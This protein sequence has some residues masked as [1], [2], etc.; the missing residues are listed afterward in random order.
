MAATF[1][2]HLDHDGVS[3]LRL[4]EGDAEIDTSQPPLAT[5]GLDDD[6]FDAR[7]GRMQARVAEADGGEAAVVLI[8]PDS[9]I[10]YTRTR[11]SGLDREADEGR[12]R[13]ALVGATP[14]DLAELVYDWHEVDGVLEIAVVA[15][16]TLDEARAFAEAHGVAPAGVLGE[17]AQ[18]AF[19]G[20]PRFGG[21]PH[22]DTPAPAPDT[23]APAAAPDP[24][25]EVNIAAPGATEPETAKPDIATPATE[26]PQPG[27][28]AGAASAPDRPGDGRAPPPAETSKETPA[29]ASPL[30]G[31]TDIDA[32]PRAEP[33]P[34]AAPSPAAIRGPASTPLPTFS[35]IRRDAP[36]SG[37]ESG[38][39]P[40]PKT[41]TDAAPAPGAASQTAIPASASESPASGKGNE[42][43]VPKVKPVETGDAAAASAA[44]LASG[45]GARRAGFGALAG[46]VLGTLGGKRRGHDA[47]AASSSLSRPSVEP[48]LS[49]QSEPPVSAADRA[50]PRHPRPSAKPDTIAPRLGSASAE[51]PGARRSGSSP[52]APE[53][54]P[55]RPDPVRRIQQRGDA[56]LPAPTGPAPSTAGEMDEASSLTVFG[57]RRMRAEPPARGGR[58]LG[59]VLTL[60]LLALMGLVALWSL[61]VDGG[62]G[63]D[64]VAESPSDT[65]AITSSV[66]PLDAEPPTPDAGATGEE[67]RQ[68]V[69]PPPADIEPAPALPEDAP[70]DPVMTP[71]TANPAADGPGESGPAPAE[72]RDLAA[73]SPDEG[74]TAPAT[75]PAR[76]PPEASVSD[77]SVA[78]RDVSPDP[79]DRAEAEAAY[80]ATGIW[81]RA[82][83]R[84]PV[85]RVT[86]DPALT[87]AA[88]DPSRL[89]Q[90][91]PA[92]PDAPGQ[93]AAPAL[94]AAPLPPGTLLDA[95]G[96]VIPTDEGALAPGGYTVYEGQPG[97]VPPAR[98]GTGEPDATD[99]RADEA[100]APVAD[101]TPATAEQEVEQDPLAQVRPTARPEDATLPETADPAASDAAADGTIDAPDIR[102]RSRP[103]LQAGGSA[104]AP[105]TGMET[106]TETDTATGTESG[107]GTA[108]DAAPEAGDTEAGDPVAPAD[109]SAAGLAAAPEARPRPR[110]E[111][112]ADEAAALTAEAERAAAVAREEAA[113]AAR[114]IAEAEL[115]SD[116]PY[117]VAA[118]PAP[119]ARPANI[120][121][122]AAQARARS[123]AET[124]RQATARAAAT[125][126]P[127]PPS[128]QTASAAAAA[129]PPQEPS[130]GP[131]V[132]RSQRVQPDV[133]SSALVARQATER[134]ALR[135]NA[136]TLIGVYGSAGQR[137][138]L[139]RLP[140]GR[141]VKVQVGDRLDGGQVAAIDRDAVRYVKRGRDVLLQMPSG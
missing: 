31:A 69:A 33:P 66:T 95:D 43:G 29:G 12:V 137:R 15:T 77:P 100:A 57:A 101:D 91:P 135:M 105:V 63:P 71:E 124:E 58:A 126:Q 48:A 24:V 127:S 106:G 86:A 92:V 23:S 85:P 111:T 94:P 103:G 68:A 120:A 73:I 81:Q 26:E 118:A 110:P 109:E 7:V 42:T 132:A 60:A 138:A 98:P 53:A 89:T 84:G 80:A 70:A 17:A 50:S 119:R 27:R 108:L 83:E 56:S 117:A 3:L 87:L 30:G 115:D 74:G 45:R 62:D 116:S 67:T 20:R 140:S 1:A 8:L 47:G 6:D 141:Y 13:N 123:A 72:P 97:I 52:A 16:E 22:D 130:R 55:A 2:L 18:G 134:N 41:T 65:P 76:L 36:Q 93:A 88:V 21:A 122:I 37:P 32:P 44:S 128:V 51:P 14:Y 38:P 121:Q 59:L 10:L 9:Q 54:Q 64:T 35:T 102:P 79:L 11:A 61:W 40:N 136:V 34:L 82:P 113:A 78:V 99:A 19:P 28:P 112:L 96:F 49:A 25:G 133:P 131:A 39:E 107:A 139:V 4:A 5:A 104:A 125:P 114:E 46:S 75:S 129:P 90:A